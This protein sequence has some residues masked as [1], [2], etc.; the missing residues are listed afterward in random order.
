MHPILI[1]IGPV[2]IHTYGFMI[3]IG[4]LVA[5]YFAIRQA[6]E[7]GLK[8]N[9]ITDL[10]FYILVSAIIGSRLLF[11]LINFSYYISNPLA[12]FKLWEGGLVFYGG[13]ILAV[14]VVLWYVKKNNLKLWQIA[15]IFAPSVAIGHAF[16]RIGCFF[17][18]CCFGKTAETLPWGVIFTNPDCLAPLNVRL[19]P[20]Q[21]YESA[22]EFINFFILLLLQKRKSYNGQVFM[23]YILIY[24]VLRFIVEIFRG[25]FARGFIISGISVSQG[26]SIIM[27]L[28]SILGILILRNKKN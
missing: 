10:S 20:T 3:A 23:T 13:V 22:G 9:I 6:K 12:I 21:L 14:P 11:V 7:E 24:S 27:F 28:T 19:H 8:S 2:T 5:L 1:K 4:F 15:D 25:D 26:I 16:G 18:G 17:A